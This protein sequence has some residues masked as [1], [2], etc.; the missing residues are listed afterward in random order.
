MRSLMILMLG[1]ITNET[2]DKKPTEGNWVEDWSVG[3]KNWQFEISG[4]GGGND[5][6]QAYTSD[7]RGTVHPSCGVF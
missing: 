4:W 6:F 1:S 7:D 2:N 3:L 5:E